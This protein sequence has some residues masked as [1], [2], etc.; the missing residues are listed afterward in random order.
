MHYTRTITFALAVALVAAAMAHSSVNVGAKRTAATAEAG[1]P[2]ES[3]IDRLFPTAAQPPDGAILLLTLRF[4]EGAND[5]ESQ[6]NIS[7][8]YRGSFNIVYYHLPVDSPS[9]DSQFVRRYPDPTVVT[10]SDVA[11]FAKSVKIESTIIHIPDADLATLV[12]Q[13]NRISFPTM[14]RKPS[15]YSVIVLHGN[16]YKLWYKTDF[17][18]FYLA[19][20]SGGDQPSGKVQ[21]SQLAEWMNRVKTSVESA[22][23]VGRQ[24][25]NLGTDNPR[26]DGTFP[27]NLPTSSLISKPRNGT[28]SASTYPLFP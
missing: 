14:A 17:G 20:T 24:T 3:V 21:A 27:N 13:L 9:I 12:D 16:Q 1:D 11:E 8:S 2:Y 7:Q 10:Q 15:K 23:R 25:G 28:M 5:R 4:K 18:E 22:M 26:T 6:I 19:Y